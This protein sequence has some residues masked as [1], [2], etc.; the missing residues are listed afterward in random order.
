MAS[1]FS[2]SSYKPKFDGLCGW[3]SEFIP[4]ASLTKT[5][6]VQ[7]WLLQISINNVV[8]H[9][10]VKLFLFLKLSLFEVKWIPNQP[11][12]K[13]LVCFTQLRA[14]QV[15]PTSNSLVS[16]SFYL[17]PEYSR[18]L[19]EKNFICVLKY[20]RSDKRAIIKSC[21]HVNMHVLMPEKVWNLHAD[22]I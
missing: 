21:W 8:V 22:N 6:F 13:V 18:T 16:S 12:L 3:F 1:I 14:N 4:L 7:F 20:F 15:N 9:L 19:K 2:H 5:K 17:L 10:D 11:T